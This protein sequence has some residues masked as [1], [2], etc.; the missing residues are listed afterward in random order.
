MTLFK[1]RI[2]PSILEYKH[3][4]GR[5]VK[6]SVYKPW[7]ISNAYNMKVPAPEFVEYMENYETRAFL[8]I[9]N[10]SI[11]Y[12]KYWDGFSDTTWSNSFS[13]AKSLV[14][15]CVGVALNEGLIQS[16]DDPMANY[17]EMF[18][19]PKKNHITIR[20]MLSMSS[21]MNYS[22]SYLN[23]F[24]FAAKANYGQ[25]LYALLSEYCANEEPGKYFKY[26]SGD[27]QSLAFLIKA[28]SG[29]SL[30]DYFSEK[31]WSQIGA[32]RD[33]LWSLDREQGDE[34]AFCCFNAN[35]RDFARIGRL[36]LQN[37]KFMGKSL[38]DSSYVQLAVQAADLLELSGD[39]NRR[40]GYQWWLGDFH[41]RAVFYARGI[42]GQYIFCIPSENMIVVR[43]GFKRA[44]NQID[45]HPED[46]YK[47]L[48]TALEIANGK[49]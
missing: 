11:V 34:K 32:K 4:P 29:K 14:S 19:T 21:G 12:E 8:V 48:Q 7:A 46:T 27:T 23:P 45:G 35:A 39:K 49:I 18:D 25:H 40:Y 43:L 3:F 26:Q 2:S 28:V 6:A 1:A 47:Y 5:I 10:D 24:G 20:H 36:M 15:L 30:S 31:I 44:S 37:G 33:A 22:E 38:I 42:N 41:N 17:L 13:M 9:K 16:L